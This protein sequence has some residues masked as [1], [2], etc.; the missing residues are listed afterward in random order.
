MAI[1]D[2]ASKEYKH[3]SRIVAALDVHSSLCKARPLLPHPFL[4]RFC[5]LGGT[6]QQHPLSRN[7]LQSQVPAFTPGR[8]NLYIPTSDW[9]Q[10]MKDDLAQLGPGFLPDYRLRQ[11]FPVDLFYL[12]RGPANSS[13]RTFPGPLTPKPCPYGITSVD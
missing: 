3:R 10:F 11:A 2:N 4:D 9:P 6:S 7:T 1:F 12:F 13:S 8:P 5:L